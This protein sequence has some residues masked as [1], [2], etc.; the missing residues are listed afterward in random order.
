V[1]DAQIHTGSKSTLE[2]QVRSASERPSYPILFGNKGPDRRGLA[3]RALG[4]WYELASE[5]NS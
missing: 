5:Y 3:E 1:L 2:L 4:M